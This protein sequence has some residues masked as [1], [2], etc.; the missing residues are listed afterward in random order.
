M[1]TTRWN[2]LLCKHG[3]SRISQFQGGLVSFQ[4]KQDKGSMNMGRIW[5]P[6]VEKEKSAWDCFP[7]SV[8][9]SPDPSHSPLCIR[10]GDTWLQGEM[11]A[12]LSQ[13]GCSVVS[14]CQQV[15]LS[16]AAS[17]SWTVL[18][19]LLFCCKCVD[20]QAEEEMLWRKVLYGNVFW[21]D[22]YQ[23]C[24]WRAWGCLDTCMDLVFLAAH[25]VSTLLLR[26]LS[27]GCRMCTLSAPGNCCTAP[28]SRGLG[29]N[30]YTRQSYPW[31]PSG[32]PT[33]PVVALGD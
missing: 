21:E 7:S 9:P 2:L 19:S 16:D 29:T 20:V 18:S 27:L 33:A 8:F 24:L 6:L 12:W 13:P 11:A 23:L 28:R 32:A 10:D 17:D 26:M 5:K 15:S 14:P 4:W 3:L 1:R 25:P 22:L 30:V 31:E